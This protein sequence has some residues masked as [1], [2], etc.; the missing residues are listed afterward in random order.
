MSRTRS[1]ANPTKNRPVFR[2]YTPATFT[3]IACKLLHSNRAKELLRMSA[4]PLILFAEDS[5]NDRLLILRGFEKAQ[6]P[7][8]V[9]PVE[10]GVCAMEYLGGKKQYADREKFPL[11]CLLLTDIKMPR[12]DGLEL[13]AWVRAQRK[14]HSLP[15]IIV[16]GSD[17]TKDR[18]RAIELGANAYVTK[19]LLLRPPAGL[20]EAILR[21][22]A[23]VLPP[24]VTESAVRA[25]RRSFL[26]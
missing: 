9:A 4:Q 5:S 18:Q 25:A 22:T 1:K 20:M 10:D 6:F 7:L 23:P 24:T 11:P 21:Y 26:Y 14:F 13:L 12:M 3:D 19:E 17:Q 8:G 16:T 2:V 15:V